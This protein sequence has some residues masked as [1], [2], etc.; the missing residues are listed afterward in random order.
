LCACAPHGR[1]DVEV[2]ALCHIM[3][4]SCRPVSRRLELLSSVS[5]HGILHDMIAEWLG[6]SSSRPCRQR[7]HISIFSLWPRARAA[8]MCALSAAAMPGIASGL[9]R[10]WAHPAR[11][12]PFIFELWWCWLMFDVEVNVRWLEACAHAR[13][14][15]RW[16]ARRVLPPLHGR[17]RPQDSPSSR[18][19]FGQVADS[20]HGLKG[21]LHRCLGAS[22]VLATHSSQLPAALCPEA[23]DAHHQADG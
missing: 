10:A 6:F 17:R 23:L 18:C 9:I 3:Q 12:N 16:Q 4:I 20:E 8:V 21:D 19:M 15:A 5:S 14:T 22:I 7:C 13:D 11:G 1:R 2:V